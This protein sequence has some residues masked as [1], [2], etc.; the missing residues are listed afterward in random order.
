[1]ANCF[2]RI[3][4]SMALLTTVASG[5]TYA[6]N[7][8]TKTVRV[9]VGFS[10]GGGVDFMAR[11]VSPRLAQAL[12]QQFIVENRP[13]ANGMIA[14]EIVAKSTPDGHVLLLA[15]GN[16][17]FASAMQ[18][19][20]IDLTTALAAVTKMVDSPLL[21]VVHPS[22]PV[23]SVKDLINL[24]KSKPNSL[25]Y[26]SGGTGGAGHMATELFKSMAKVDLLHIPFKGISPAITDAIAGN[27]PVCFCTLPSTL[28]QARAGRLRALAVTTSNRTS[29]APEIPTVAEAGVP[30]Y[31][32]SQWYGVMA[33]AGTPTPI[34]ERL[35]AEISVALALPDLR[36]SL[37]AAGADPVKSSPQEFSLYFKQEIEKWTRIVKVAGIR[38]E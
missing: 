31:E 36:A 15:P 27:V 28:P 17:A 26:G 9:L 35:S 3:F 23:K 6:Q 14:A 34:L 22:L 12:G 21:V 19:L 25:T 18:K 16:Y 5:M 1:M 7:Y 2:R 4:L 37:L 8:P 30:G 38:P 20:P 33:P 11:S 10:A 32:M 13:G 29:A 24:A